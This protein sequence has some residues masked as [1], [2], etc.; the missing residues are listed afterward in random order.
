M[1]K[2]NI[3]IIVEGKYDKA[4]LTSLVDAVVIS[5]DGFGIFKNTEK[6]ELLKSLAKKSGVIVLTD[7]DSAG[8]IIR[9]YLKNIIGD[10]KI[11]H[12]VL[13]EIKGKERRKSKPS[14][15]G[16]L[17]VEGTDKQIILGALKKFEKMGP[18]T[19]NQS[20]VVTK[21]DLFEFGLSGG[22]NSKAKRE[23]LLKRL[24]IPTSTAPNTMLRLLNEMTSADEIRDILS[25]M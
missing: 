24:G 9:S 18:E 21:A 6:Q 11:Y 1:L 17:G 22:S 2:I 20:A 8:S 25:E 3:P 23:Y 4:K 5:T 12:V 19:S 10:D 13:P 15:D 14:S 7:S 16:L